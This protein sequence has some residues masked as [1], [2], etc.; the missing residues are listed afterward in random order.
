M[1][2]IA[3]ASGIVELAD[4]LAAHRSALDITAHRVRVRRLGA[5]ADFVHE[6]GEAGLR[7]VGGR[8]G[9]RRA[10]EAQ[11]PGLGE[12]ELLAFLERQLRST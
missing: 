5:L 8:R 9:A 11:A 4:A 1:S 2:S 12:P 6:Y 7:A 10:L 3:P